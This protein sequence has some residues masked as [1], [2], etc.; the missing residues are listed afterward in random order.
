MPLC[1]VQR[2]KRTVVPDPLPLA[3]VVYAL[4][5]VAN[6]ERPL[7]KKSDNPDGLPTSGS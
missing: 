6:C 2:G 7:N 1:S 5:N 4:K 3:Y